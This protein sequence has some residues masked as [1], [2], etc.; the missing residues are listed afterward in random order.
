MKYVAFLDILGF[1][2]H[3]K[4]IS[5]NEARKFISCFAQTASKVWTLEKGTK[6]SGYIVSDSFI[7]YS[8]DVSEKSLFQVVNMVEHICRAEFAENG[9]FVR[10]AIAKGEFDR[11]PAKDLSDL[12][13]E[14]MVGQAYVDAYL[15]EDSFRAMGIALS[16]DVYHD[17]NM[18]QIYANKVLVKKEGKD[19]PPLFILKYLTLDFLLE[20]GN[21]VKFVNLAI[22]SN[23]LP[24]Y[25]NTLGFALENAGS[26]KKVVQVFPNIMN[27]VSKGNPSENWQQVDVFIEKAFDEDVLFN[28]KRRFLKF[29]RLNISTKSDKRA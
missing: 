12:Q 18:L 6:L 21:L 22:E 3:L 13:K 23:W 19:K 16:E 5:Q 2:D 9:I 14:L 8:S 15:M 11:I 27:I 24:H 20:G 10:G 29:I 26:S 4:V 25:Y 7:I 17:V 1:K 28:F